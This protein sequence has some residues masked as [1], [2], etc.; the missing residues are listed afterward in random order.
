MYCYIDI[1][2]ISNFIITDFDSVK[3]SSCAEVT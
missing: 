2:D 3:R 1:I